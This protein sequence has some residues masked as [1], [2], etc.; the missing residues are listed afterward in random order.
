MHS[1]QSLICDLEK[2]LCNINFDAVANNNHI[3]INMLKLILFLFIIAYNANAQDYLDEP[4]LKLFYGESI[5]DRIP[6][7]CV[8][9]T[10]CYLANVR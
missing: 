7:S 4:V 5:A 8:E 3:R 1:K 9:A 10:S 2:P 6:A